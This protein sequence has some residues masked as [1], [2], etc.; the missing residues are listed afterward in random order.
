MR[1]SKAT[2]T[3]STSRASSSSPIVP[4]FRFTTRVDGDFADV[5]R[6]PPGT[7]WLHQVHGATVVEVDEPGAR[8]GSD[9]DAAFTGR[10]GCT[11]A[12]RTADC[13]P[14]VLVNE[15]AIGVVHAGW[16][17]L[18]DGVI[19]AA[20]DA[21]GAPVEA[22]IGPH[23]RRGCYEFGAADLDAVAS[24][25]GAHVRA[26]TSW[27]T[28]ALDLT[29]G[30]RGALRGVRLHDSGACTACADVFFSWRARG[31]RERFATLAWLE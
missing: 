23:I 13:V 11:L 9:A 24:A 15:A 30:V 16:R 8:A 5:T 21:M 1:I 10:R 29:A 6:F 26:T 31:E 12:V 17:G 22:H 25:L 14:V 18:A 19:E 2:T 28:P 20:V 4:R 3:S 7:T 27:G